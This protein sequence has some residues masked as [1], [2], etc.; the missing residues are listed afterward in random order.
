[1]INIKVQL[2]S[3]Y[4]FFYFAGIFNNFKDLLFRIPSN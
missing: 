1:M 4:F 3:L 2:K